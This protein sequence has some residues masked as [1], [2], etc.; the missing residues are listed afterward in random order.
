METHTLTEKNLKELSETLNTHISQGVPVGDD[1]K[2]LLNKLQRLH[3]N[4]GQ[5]Y[6]QLYLGD[7]EEHIFQALIHSH[8]GKHSPP[9]TEEEPV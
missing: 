6:A 5:E 4:P 3:P 8:Y 2:S 7:E 1:G 9:P